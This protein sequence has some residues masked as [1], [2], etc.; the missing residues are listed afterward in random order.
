M[1][2]AF[3]YFCV[4]ATGLLL[5]SVSSWVAGNTSDEIVTYKEYLG[6][7]DLIQRLSESSWKFDKDAE[8]WI[9]HDVRV[10][11][12]P[13]DKFLLWDVEM[14]TIVKGRLHRAKD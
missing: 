5:M 8:Y 13:S 14:D 1:K 11:K 6:H 10:I 3:F 9:E 12:T 7:D 4:L 2:Y